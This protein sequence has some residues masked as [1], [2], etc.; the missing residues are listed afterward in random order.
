[1]LS[2]KEVLDGLYKICLKKQY[3]Q[4]NGLVCIF[5]YRYDI[6]HQNEF[7][8]LILCFSALKTFLFIKF[9]RYIVLM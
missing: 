8:N 6:Y 1:M 4:Y 9:S 5:M 7:F 2:E 3:A